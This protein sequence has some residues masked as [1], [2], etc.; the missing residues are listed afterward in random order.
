MPAETPAPAKYAPINYLRAIHIDH[1]RRLRCA[2]C[3]CLAHTHRTQLMALTRHYAT[4]LTVIR[5]ARLSSSSST[6]AKRALREKT[7]ELHVRH[8]RDGKEGEGS[9]DK[10]GKR[11][12]QILK[13]KLIRA[14]QAHTHTHTHMTDCSTADR[15]NK[16]RYTETLQR[17]WKKGKQ[18]ACN[19]VTGD[20]VC[21][22]WNE[23]QRTVKT[24]GSRSAQTGHCSPPLISL[25]F[26]FPL[27]SYPIDPPTGRV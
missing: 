11:M 15:A 9:R 17:N 6:G 8:L 19:G 1:W 18:S 27:P 7:I 22:R 20:S 2:K 21:S 12:A 5:L 3:M 10:Y 23:A 4:L 25:S 26:L 14:G 24:N 16:H 13:S